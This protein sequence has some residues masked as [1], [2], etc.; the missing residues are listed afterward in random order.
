MCSWWAASIAL[1]R[2]QRRALEPARQA[3]AAAELQREVG[4]AVVLA[5]FVDLDDVG[6]LQPRDR[7]R[8]AAKAVEAFVIGVAAGEDHLEGDDAVQL[9]VPGLVDDAHAAPAQ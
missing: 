5:D 6:V 2:R 7:R 9:Q 3:A 1:A 8:L 4:Q